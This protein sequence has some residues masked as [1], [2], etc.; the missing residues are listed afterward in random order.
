MV[1]QMQMGAPLQARIKVVHDVPELRCGSCGTKIGEVTEIGPTGTPQEPRRHWVR[2][3]PGFGL[4]LTS[5]IYTLIPLAQRQRNAARRAGSPYAEFHPR[6][7]RPNAAKRLTAAA[8]GTRSLP[9]RVQQR[10]PDD[11]T[12]P[13]LTIPARTFC[14][15][16]PRCCRLVRADTLEEDHQRIGLDA[17]HDAIKRQAAQWAADETDTP[18]DHP[19]PV[20]GC[21]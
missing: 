17:M 10:L 11:W 16:C 7:R 2:L 1:G 21:L 15:R 18:Q 5:G 6:S 20:C 14:F 4:E 12:L 9:P 8:G 3:I 13:S 19:V